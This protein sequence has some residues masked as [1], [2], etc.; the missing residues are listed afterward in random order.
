MKSESVSDITF[1]NIILDNA[2]RDYNYR[3]NFAS[4]FFHMSFQNLPIL[5]LIAVSLWAVR[6]L[7]FGRFIKSM[8]HHYAPVE[9]TE[10]IT[11]LNRT[12]VLTDPPFMYFLVLYV[13]IVVVAAAFF[14]LAVSVV[15]LSAFG[16]MKPLSA[17]L[18]MIVV[19]LIGVVTVSY[20]FQVKG[21]IGPGTHSLRSN[22][23]T[24]LIAAGLILFTA[25]SLVLTTTG[26]C[27]ADHNEYENSLGVIDGSGISSRFS[28]SFLPPTCDSE[29]P[30]NLICH[31]YLTVPYDGSREMFVNFQIMDSACMG[32]SC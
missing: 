19:M 9:G 5:I 27:V 13:E 30:S 6:K 25:G 24:V 3:E 21:T 8:K 23:K 20:E 26:L 15:P 28:R 14:I 7:T 29:N 16:F 18:Y 10:D 22:K 31:V 32:T 12:R 1:W 17:F 4:K 2:Q 11:H